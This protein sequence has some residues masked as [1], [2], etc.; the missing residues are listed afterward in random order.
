MAF[1]TLA[2]WHTVAFAAPTVLMMLK[3][4]TRRN[5]V[6]NLEGWDDGDERYIEGGQERDNRNVLTAVDGLLVVLVGIVMFLVSRV[7]I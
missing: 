3:G 6:F 7:I 2:K 4:L 5:I 1:R